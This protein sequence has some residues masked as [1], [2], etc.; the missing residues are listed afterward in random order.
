[1]KGKIIKILENS[2]GQEYGFIRSLDRETEEGEDYY[3]DNRYLSEGTM[4]D[5][6]KEDV[7]DFTPSTNPYK[8]EQQVAQDVSL[9]VGEIVQ[10]ATGFFGDTEHIC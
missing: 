4:S 2:Y 3:F 9:A 7:V 1:M 6:Y 10:Q 5:F 8:P